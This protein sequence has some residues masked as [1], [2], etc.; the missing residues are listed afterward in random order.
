MKACIALSNY[1]EN[2]KIKPLKDGVVEVTFQIYGIS[3][4]ELIS[5]V[6]KPLDIKIEVEK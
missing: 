4:D 5:F 2:P 1:G 3:L 6:K